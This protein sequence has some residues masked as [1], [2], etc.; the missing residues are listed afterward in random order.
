MK[1][2]NSIAVACLLITPIRLIMY[3]IGGISTDIIVMR[4][5]S[6]ESASTNEAHSSVRINQILLLSVLGSSSAAH[7]LALPSTEI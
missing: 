4:I 1:I 2:P 6:Y 7:L 5:Q 3:A